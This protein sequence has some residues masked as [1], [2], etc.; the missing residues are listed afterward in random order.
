ML[1]SSKIIKLVVEKFERTKG[2]GVE[3]KSS[4]NTNYSKQGQKSLSPKC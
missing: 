2:S 1:K 4:L 3:G